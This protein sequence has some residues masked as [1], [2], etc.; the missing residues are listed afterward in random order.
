[1]AIENFNEISE[2]FEANKDSDDVA[3]YI[4]G[5][6]TPDRVSAFLESDD[7]K[8]I[9]QPK[10]DSFATKAIQ[11]HDEKF[12]L[13]ELPKL[14]E[15]K[16]KELHPEADPKDNEIAA[17]KA[18]FE[19]MQKT[20]AREKLTNF[21]LKTAQEKKLPSSLIRYFIGEDEETTI[22]NLEILEDEFKTSVNSVAEDRMKDGY[23]PPKSDSKAGGFTLE[24][25]KGMSQ[26]EMNENIND[27][28]KA[29]KSK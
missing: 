3:N 5:F 17:L 23:K 6:L 11:T 7:G 25:I 13:N 18:Q 8:K 26:A 4:K 29:L 14:V 27:V 12:K 2:Y 21:A 28:L 22:K 15:A 10:L 19:N 24:Q 9:I 16:Y 1:M 20:A